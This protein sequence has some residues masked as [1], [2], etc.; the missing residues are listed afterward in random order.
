[1]GYYDNHDMIPKDMMP[2]G[3]GGDGC[4]CLW[5]IITVVSLYFAVSLFLGLF[6]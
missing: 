3:G 2:S 6:E 1:M 4:G 5:L